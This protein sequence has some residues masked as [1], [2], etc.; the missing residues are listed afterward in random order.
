MSAPQLKHHARSSVLAY[1]PVPVPA[2]DYLK[3]QFGVHRTDNFD[4]GFFVVAH[5]LAN[6]GEHEIS[7]ASFLKMGASANHATQKKQVQR[8]RDA[9]VIELVKGASWR[10]EKKSARVFRI[11]Q[12]LLDL[13]LS[14]TEARAHAKPNDVWTRSYHRS[15]PV[16]TL[17]DSF[18][19][20]AATEPMLAPAI[21]QLQARP[22]GFD[23]LGFLA[24]HQGKRGLMDEAVARKHLS[25]ALALSDGDNYTRYR[26]A[27][28][29]RIISISP[30]LQGIPKS[31]RG[32]WFFPQPGHTLLDFDFRTAESWIVAYRSGDKALL[33]VLDGDLYQVVADKFG[34]D[35]NS[36][37]KPMLNAYNYGAGVATLAR[38]AF[39][40]DDSEWPSPD[41][42]AVAQEFRRFMRLS[43]PTATR[44]LREQAKEIRKTGHA[45]SASGFLRDKI[46]PSDA[47]GAGVNHVVQGTG[48]DILREILRTLYEELG[49]GGYFL[50][51]MHDGLLVEVSIAQVSVIGE[52]VKR[53]MEG[54]CRKFLPGPIPIEQLDGWRDKHAGLT[55]WNQR[56]ARFDR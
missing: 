1:A 39:G 42:W 54:A 27:V 33:S 52:I 34:L 10:E 11:P 25:F 2:C 14:S 43:F 3:A 49:A 46:A 23:R 37:V 20:L 48:A 51:P 9:G 7:Q 8:L 50:L 4:L 18:D 15:K 16:T 28:S 19:V 21:L 38:Q 26:L 36:Q 31:M 53:A 44:W 32:P 41:E 45:V 17:N 56:P 47:S 30:N 13:M 35:R 6:G 29:G 40:L 24:E 12:P 55:V 22:L 5:I